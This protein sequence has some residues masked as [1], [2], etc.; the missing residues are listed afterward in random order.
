MVIWGG[1]SF[2]A[3]KPREATGAAYDPALDRWRILPK[4]PVD[5]RSGHVAAFTGKEMLVWGGQNAKNPT[6]SDGAAYNPKTDS[7]RRIA[8]SPLRGGVGF[9]GVWTG[10]EWLLVEAN[11]PGE[12]RA[13]SGK[14]AAYNPAADTW[15]EI[16]DAPLRPGFGA[17]ATWTGTTLVVIRFS[18]HES[19]GAQYD[20]EVDKWTS[21][22]GNPGLGLQAYD[23]A[24]LTGDGLLVTR[25]TVQTTNGI[26]AGPAAWVYDPSR[27]VWSSVT[28]P[29]AQLPYGRPVLADGMVIYYAPGGEQSWAYS[30]DD[31]RWIAVPIVEDRLREFWTT[32]WTGQD[33]LVWGGSN[34]GGPTT[35]DGRALHVSG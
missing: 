23:F 27:M 29:P 34:P 10:T 33:L 7:W 25:D 1:E 5:V 30:P 11:K 3:E 4:A 12:P 14:G 26:Q 28:A 18:E 8:P 13:P 22:P 20:P 31:E 24:T 6:L 17:T 9:V 16:A 21:I 32:V 2:P 35:T 15:R 19:R